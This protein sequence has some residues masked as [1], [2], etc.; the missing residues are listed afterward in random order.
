MIFTVFF[1][2]QLIWIIVCNDIVCYFFSLLHQLLLKRTGRVNHN[3]H[4]R[5]GRSEKT[6]LKI[7]MIYIRFSVCLFSCFQKQFLLFC[8]SSYSLKSSF[9]TNKLLMK[10]N[11]LPTCWT[12]RAQIIAY[13]SNW[14][15]AEFAIFKLQYFF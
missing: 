3:L 7:T 15:M 6:A 5:G 1:F 11:K 12:I 14:L 10:V 8:F 4:E 2:K 9:I 13:Y